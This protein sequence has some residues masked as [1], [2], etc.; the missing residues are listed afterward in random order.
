MVQKKG[1]PKTP[2]S[3]RKKGSVN[4]S[5]REMREMYYE[6]F[7]RAGGVEYLITQA[8]ENPRAFL[9]MGQRLIPQAVEAKIEGAL[10][11]LVLDQNYILGQTRELKGDSDE[12][13]GD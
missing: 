10:V 5:T 6:A 8:E 11:E 7:E 1:D 9:A 13:V 3:G 12:E 4:K 2:G